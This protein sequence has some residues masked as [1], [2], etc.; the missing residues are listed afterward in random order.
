M[1]KFVKVLVIVLCVLLALFVI[2]SGVLGYIIASK[3]LDQN[4]GKDTH[5]NS[6]MQMEVWGYDYS[7]FES[8]YTGSSVSAVA[9]DGNEV[10]GTLYDYGS[11]SCVV[12]VHGAG[13]DRC[14]MYPLAEEYLER[15]YDVIAIDQRGCGSNP[16]SEVTFGIRESLDVEAMVAYARS[17]GYSSVFV[18][19]QSM[20]AQTVAI[21][22]SNVAA[23]SSSAADAVICDSPVPGMELIILEMF[24]DGDTS[25]PLANYLVAISKPWLALKGISMD[26]GDTIAVVASDT[27]P[28]LV[29]VSTLDETCLPSQVEDVYANIACENKDILYFESKHIEGVIDYPDEYM[30]GVEAFL[31]GV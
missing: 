27:I 5:N 24:G 1:K 26:D 4:E 22:A 29:I 25:S 11:S 13:G 16:S 7:A 17:L 15:G 23:G 30:D 9:S 6:L 14:C 31:D 18:H 2:G 12:L 8:A 3:I 28:T 19:G 10:P 20:G 21:Y